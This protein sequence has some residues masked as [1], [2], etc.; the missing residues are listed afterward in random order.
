MVRVHCMHRRRSADLPDGSAWSD[1]SGCGALKIDGPFSVV[2]HGD[3]E[4]QAEARLWHVHENE[5]KADVM[6]APHHGSKN[7]STADFVAAVAPQLVIFPAGWH[8]RFHHPR[9]EVVAR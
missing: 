2:L 8:N 1:N 4:R 6:I 9:P 7:S 3:S 5:L